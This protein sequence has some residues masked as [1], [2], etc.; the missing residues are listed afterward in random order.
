MEQLCNAVYR[1]ILWDN[2][3]WVIAA[4]ILFLLV[5]SLIRIARSR[6]P[7]LVKI[8]GS[9]FSFLA[10]FWLGVA[11]L[12]TF[13]IVNEVYTQYMDFHVVNAAIKNTCFLDPDKKHCPTTM[14]EVIAIQPEVL[15]PLLKDT[16]VYFNHPSVDDPNYTLLIKSRW[17]SGVIFDP[18]LATMQENGADFVHTEFRCSSTPVI[19]SS[20]V[21]EYLRTI[22]PTLNP[23]PELRPAF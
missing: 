3:L 19:T 10:A 11:V 13:I 5:F 15:E 18:R 21:E 17:A 4:I 7:G 6:Y 16:T 12:I 20:A 1:V 2:W 8:I 23:K 14:A 22:W 9:V